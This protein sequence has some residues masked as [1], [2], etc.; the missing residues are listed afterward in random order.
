MTV[1]PMTHWRGDVAVSGNCHALCVRCRTSYPAEGSVT[2]ADAWAKHHATT[3]AEEPN[4][5]GTLL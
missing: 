4:E 5:Q 1:P 2:D 3:H